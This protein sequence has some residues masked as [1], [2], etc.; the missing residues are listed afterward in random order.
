MLQPEEENEA[1]VRRV[2]QD[3]INKFA[4]LNAKLH[5]LRDER[6]LLK[7]SRKKSK[8]RSMW[9]RIPY[10]C[11]DFLSASTMS[12]T[13]CNNEDSTGWKW[14]DAFIVTKGSSI[15]TTLLPVPFPK[16]FYEMHGD[17]RRRS[18]PLCLI[19]C[20]HI[21]RLSTFV[22]VVFSNESNHN[23]RNHWND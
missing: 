19:K 8:W 3:N 6:D 15:Q 13:K 12:T 16:C 10:S 9:S 5:E 21:L 4:R 20:F 18:L 7:V 22:I 11:I 23:R 1:E 2:D 14:M 17:L